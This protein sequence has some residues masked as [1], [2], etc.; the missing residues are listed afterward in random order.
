MVYDAAD[1]RTG[2]I[3]PLGIRTTA[4]YDCASRQIA[5]R[6][7]YEQFLAQRDGYGLTMLTI[8]DLPDED[9]RDEHQEL[10]ESWTIRFKR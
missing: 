10:E 5:S 1:R 6:V 3:R 8:D 9:E 2:T 4:V 7:L